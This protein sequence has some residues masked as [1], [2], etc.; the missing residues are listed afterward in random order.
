MKDLW[1]DFAMATT[2]VDIEDG[3]TAEHLAQSR[4]VATAVDSAASTALEKAGSSAEST[5]GST[6]VEMDESWV[7]RTVE[8]LGNSSDAP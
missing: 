1:S 2:T 4:A 8:P 5:A 6:A 7:D 3:E